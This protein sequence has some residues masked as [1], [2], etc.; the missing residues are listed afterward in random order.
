M[1]DRSHKELLSDAPRPVLAR[2]TV[3]CTFRPAIR[4]DR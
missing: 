2:M 1:K 3:R 4:T